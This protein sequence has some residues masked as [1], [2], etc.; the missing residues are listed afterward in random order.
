MVV[1]RYQQLKSD[2]EALQSFTEKQ[3]ALASQMM[4][5]RHLIQPMSF[6]ALTRTLGRF[7]LAQL[8]IF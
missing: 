3:G 6:L 8:D 7:Y 1:K 4:K 2:E 5:V